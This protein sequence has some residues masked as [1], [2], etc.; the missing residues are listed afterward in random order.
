MGSAPRRIRFRNWREFHRDYLLE[1]AAL[2]RMGRSRLLFRGHSDRGWALSPTLDRLRPVGFAGDQ[3]RKEHYEFLLAEFRREAIRFVSPPLELPV[4]EAFELLARH[5][6]VPSPIIDWTES[7]YVAAFFAYDQP[8]SEAS[9]H[10]VAIWVL[11]RTALDEEKA[12][13]RLIDDPDLL[14]VNPRAL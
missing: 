10:H 5:H 14:R 4:G 6:G 3:E 13:V 2:D 9:G 12:Q 11:D 7:P 1:F 8:L